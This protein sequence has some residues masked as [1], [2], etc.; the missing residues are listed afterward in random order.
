MLGSSQRSWTNEAASK[1]TMGTTKLRAFQ[2]GRNLQICIVIKVKLGIALWSLCA[3]VEGKGAEFELWQESISIDASKFE[4]SAFKIFF[5]RECLWL[6]MAEYLIR[7]CDNCGL[8]ANSS[9]NRLEICTTYDLA[10]FTQISLFEIHSFFSLP[11]LIECGTL[12]T[13]FGIICI[14]GFFPGVHTDLQ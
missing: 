7:C 14:D 11:P 2:K 12:A 10:R 3:Q 8:F 9:L 1:Q 6:R 5:Q 4:L 13:L